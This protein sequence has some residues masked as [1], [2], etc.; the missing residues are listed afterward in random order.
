MGRHRHRQPCPHGGSDLEQHVEHELGDLNTRPV[1]AYE[2]RARVRR[3][4][5][6]LPEGAEEVDDLGVLLAWQV[7]LI[8]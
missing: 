5:T 1:R 3:A 7:G 8:Q 4:L 6:A 2:S